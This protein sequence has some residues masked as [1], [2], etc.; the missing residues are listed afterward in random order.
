MDQ[1]KIKDQIIMEQLLSTLCGD[2]CVYMKE[3]RLKKLA[4]LLIIM[5]QENSNKQE[6]RSEAGTHDQKL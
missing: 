2:I 3:R 4:N 1:L 6:S 5:L